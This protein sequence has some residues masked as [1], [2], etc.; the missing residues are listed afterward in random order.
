MR[1]FEARAL[2]G[3]AWLKPAHSGQPPGREALNFSTL[4]IYGE[5]IIGAHRQRKIITIADF[6]SEE[7]WRRDPDDG[8]GPSV[9]THSAVQ[10]RRVSGEFPLPEGVTDHGRRRAATSHVVLRREDAAQNRREPP[11]PEKKSALTYNPS[12]GRASPPFARLNP[13][14][15]PGHGS[16]KGIGSPV[17]L[18]PKRIR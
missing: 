9:Q 17:N 7:T 4:A 1:R 15:A 5:Q 2:D 6:Y 16:I 10:D 8:Y 12:A 3:P 11:A 14:C 13:R 18:L